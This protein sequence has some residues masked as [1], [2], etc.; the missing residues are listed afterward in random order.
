MKMPGHRSTEVSAQQ[1]K[2]QSIEAS[3]E[4][5]REGLTG[6]MSEVVHVACSKELP[7]VI[8]S[9]SAESAAKSPP[10]TTGP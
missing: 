8:G 10:C 5:G 2:D 3:R 6:E 9:Q 7:R 4:A 1:F